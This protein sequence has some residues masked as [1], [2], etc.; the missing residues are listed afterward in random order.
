VNKLRRGIDLLLNDPRELHRAIG[1]R[2]RRWLKLDY[3][4]G[5]GGKAAGPYVV[6]LR[7]T[8]RCNLRCRMCFLYGELG[9]GRPVKAR[10]SGPEDMTLADW[11]AAI[12]RLAPHKPSI[13]ITGG[14][15]TLHG[16]CFEIIRHV[17]DRGLYCGMVTNGTLL[18]EKAEDV[19]ASGRKSPAL[20]PE[21]TV[22]SAST[23]VG[24]T[25]R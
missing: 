2:L 23:P 10:F 1:R 17:K 6:S 9:D 24:F 21:R 18:R 20:R 15:P 19:V 22:S 8:Y 5:R 12:D 16:H 25:R 14:E 4:F 11:K 7:L 13:G 3:R